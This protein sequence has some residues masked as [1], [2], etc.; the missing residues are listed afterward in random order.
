M[1]LR[2]LCL[3]LLLAA[4]VPCLCAQSPWRDNLH[5]IDDTRHALADSMRGPQSPLNMVA[6]IELKPGETTVGSAPGTVVSLRNIS[7]QLVKLRLQGD[8]L[9]VEPPPAGFPRDL[10]V[11]GSPA[12]AGPVRFD[13]D[14]TSPVFQQGSVSFVLRHKFGFYL[15]ARDLQASNVLHAQALRWYAPLPRYRIMA[16]WKPWP[17]SQTLRVANILGQV[18]EKVSYGVA[19]F[20]IDGRTYQLEPSVNQGREKPLFFV[21]RDRTSLRS[22]YGVG[23][24]LDAQMPSNGLSQ[25]GTVV[26]DFNQARNPWCA[27]SPHTSCP[28]PP[29]QNRLPIAIPA[30]EKRHL[31]PHA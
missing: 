17:K 5:E 2:R 1:K 6:L 3:W 4:A 16:Q 19:E 23:R 28:I 21:F 26:L 24:F 18:N 12:A 20:R 31:G 9:V 22:T 25:P 13:Q 15:V 27:F 29:V 14:G 10:R 30:G 7:P 11:G 8:V